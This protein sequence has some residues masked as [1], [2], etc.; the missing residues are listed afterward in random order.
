MADHPSNSENADKIFGAKSR[1]TIEFP[2]L[3]VRHLLTDPVIVRKSG[4]VFNTVDLAREFGFQVNRFK[5][6][7]FKHTKSALKYKT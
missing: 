4:R 5:V 7:R 6:H 3:C 1:E 2:G